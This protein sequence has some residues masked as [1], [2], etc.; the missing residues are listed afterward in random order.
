MQK[1]NPSHLE[2]SIKVAKCLLKAA[3]SWS[4][5]FRKMAKGVAVFTAA[6]K[7]TIVSA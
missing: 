6:S 1:A 4:E 5:A 7:N 2:I 3:Y